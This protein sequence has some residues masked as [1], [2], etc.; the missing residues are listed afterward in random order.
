MT[1]L[2]AF[3]WVMVPVDRHIL[4]AHIT[5]D[6]RSPMTGGRRQRSRHCIGSVGL[7]L[8]AATRVNDDSGKLLPH[9]ATLIALVRVV[10]DRHTLTTQL[11]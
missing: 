7:P 1:T 11:Y 5:L 3:A 8:F 10:V 6:G 2:S 9:M 4:T